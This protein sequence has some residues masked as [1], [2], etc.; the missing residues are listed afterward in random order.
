[1]KVL[2]SVVFKHKNL[3]TELKKIHPNPKGRDF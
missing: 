2:G 3:G 1:M